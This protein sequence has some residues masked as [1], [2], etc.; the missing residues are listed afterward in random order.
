MDCGKTG[1]L[2]RALRVE[3]GLTQRE[4][5]DRLAL[6]DRTVSK[7]ERGL[8]APD[9]SL[10]PDVARVLNVSIETL[11]AGE[12][13]END[14]TGGNM[15]RNHYYVCPTCGNLVMSTGGVVISCCGK[16]LEEAKP[17]KAPED[18]RLTVTPVEDEWY[19]TSGHPM[20]KEH[21]IAFVAF[22]TGERVEL[23]RCYPE[24][25]LQLRLPRRGH[26]LLLWYCTRHG[27]FTQPL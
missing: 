13:A 23:V 18:D 6:S 9:V 20:T 24:W 5:A 15:K 16:Q 8:G 2:I 7:W 4:L 25:D 1:G 22:A 14:P 27:L 10:L 17:Q 11:L 19:I 12:L 21:H 3:L 26:G